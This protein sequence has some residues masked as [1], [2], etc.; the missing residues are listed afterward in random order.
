MD[1]L[2]YIYYSILSLFY[3]N[4]EESKASLLKELCETTKFLLFDLACNPIN[5][6]K[7]D[8]KYEFTD[9]ND[10]KI[11]SYVKKYGYEE[12]IKILCNEWLDDDKTKKILS[13]LSNKNLNVEN[14]L[15]YYYCE[16]VGFFTVNNIDDI[17]PLLDV[18][19]GIF[20]EYFVVHKYF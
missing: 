11:C 18:F 17:S 16:Y 3:I 14:E 8:A 5:E 19:F 12:G 10:L 4:M 6:P 9:S 20:E 7:S 15:F 2:E 13:E 1:T